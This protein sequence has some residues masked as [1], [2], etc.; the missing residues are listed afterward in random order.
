MKS[1]SAFFAIL[2]LSISAYA[3]KNLDDKFFIITVAIIGGNSELI[4]EYYWIIPYNSIKSVDNYS[5]FPFYMDEVDNDDIKNCIAGKPL[6]ML[7]SYQGEDYNLST[8]LKKNIK[9]LRSIIRES[10][11]KFL[12]IEK[13]WTEKKFQKLLFYITPVRGDFCSSLIAETS[14]SLF[15]YKGPVYIPLM[16]S[17]FDRDLLHSVEYQYL[18]QSDFSNFYFANKI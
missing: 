10:K 14:G 6:N 4:E 15:N 8:N 11:K 16:N 13:K 5:I 2:L 17:E 9:I 1:K 7:I 12:T 18:I 3:Q